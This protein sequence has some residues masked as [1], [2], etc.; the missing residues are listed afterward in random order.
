MLGSRTFAVS[1]GGVVHAGAISLYMERL[2]CL[3][4]PVPPLIAPCPFRSTRTRPS[5]KRV[6]RQTRSS[7]RA[8]RPAG[9]R[10]IGQANECLMLMVMLGISY[11]STGYMLMLCRACFRGQRKQEDGPWRSLVVVSYQPGRQGTGIQEMLCGSALLDRC[12]PR[13]LARSACSAC[14]ASMASSSDG[15]WW[16]EAKMTGI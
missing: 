16:T 14:I 2:P 8:A 6:A 4:G 10:R 1:M 15:P 7:R 5:G 9:I 11:T 13:S 3:C 12:R